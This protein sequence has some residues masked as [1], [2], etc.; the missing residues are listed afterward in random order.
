[1]IDDAVGE[2]AVSY[3]NDGVSHTNVSTGSNERP[4]TP[5][6]GTAVRTSSWRPGAHQVLASPTRSTGDLPDEIHNSARQALCAITL[7]TLSRIGTSSDRWGGFQRQGEWLRRAVT[8][9]EFGARK[10]A[11]GEWDGA[12]GLPPTSPIL[13]HRT[14]ATKRGS[15]GMFSR[16][17]RREILVL[18]RADPPTPAQVAC[19]LEDGD[20]DVPEEVHSGTRKRKVSA[21]MM[22]PESEPSFGSG[23]SPPQ[24]PQDAPDLAPNHTR[25]RSAS[26]AVEKSEEDDD[27]CGTKVG[28]GGR[29]SST[30]RVEGA[31]AGA[32]EGEDA[33]RFGC[34]L[35]CEWVEDRD[36]DRDG[37]GTSDKA[38]CG[39]DGN[40]VSKNGVWDAGSLL[41]AFEGMR[42]AV[43]DDSS[44]SSRAQ[45]LSVSHAALP[46]LRVKDAVPLAPRIVACELGSSALANSVWRG[47]RRS[48][49]RA[50]WA[51]VGDCFHWALGGDIARV[52]ASSSRPSAVPWS[53]PAWSLEWAGGGGSAPRRRAS[54]GEFA[55]SSGP[56]LSRI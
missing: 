26:F 3:S 34:I 33:W 22:D 23:G 14:I 1:M 38:S 49:M 13:L 10:A 41:E 29:A 40:G 11:A 18:A 12:S 55:A 50:G 51:E 53:E 20:T 37:T 45:A 54:D 36:R 32:G 21:V 24:D 48:A 19:A 28:G 8:S 39:G 27:A 7:A 30:R 52:S 46:S 43:P 44:A 25:A 5:K 56:R 9:A 17:V 35:I 15:G 16:D 6:R 2:E 42:G 4:G 31:G 47:A